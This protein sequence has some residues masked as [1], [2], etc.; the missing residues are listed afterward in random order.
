MASIKDLKRD[1]NST[2]GAL[3]EQVYAYEAETGNEGSEEGTVIIDNSIAL[4][5]DLMKRVHQKDVEDKKSHFRSIRNDLSQK[6]AE[7]LSSLHE[8]SPQA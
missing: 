8:M 5:D 3:I 6:S 7:L 1:I 4:F 2:L